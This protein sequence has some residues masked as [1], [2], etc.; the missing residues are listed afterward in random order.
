[1]NTT[2]DRSQQL[3]YQRMKLRAQCAAQRKELGSS[4]AA[5]EEHLAGVDR[6]VTIAR[7]V[8]TKP[9]VIATSVAL[10]TL[11]GPKRV[12]RWIGRGALWYST[13][14]RLIKSLAAHKGLI[15]RSKTLTQITQSARRLGV[16]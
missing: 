8:V 13:G 9:A 4:F 7:R 15:G 3:A 12:V 5:I 11:I 6:A 1:M 16:E 10:L 2:F 14:S